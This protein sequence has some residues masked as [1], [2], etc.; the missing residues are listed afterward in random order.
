ME[1]GPL[2]EMRKKESRR[3]LGQTL[4]SFINEIQRRGRASTTYKNFDSYFI[5]EAFRRAHGLPLP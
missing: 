3:A 5:D 2:N 1:V 4:D